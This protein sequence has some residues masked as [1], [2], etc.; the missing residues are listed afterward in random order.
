MGIP[1]TAAIPRASIYR[2][3]CHLKH[4]TGNP[5]TLIITTDLLFFLM[6]RYGDYHINSLKKIGRQKFGS[7]IPPHNCTYFLLSTIFQ[8]MKNQAEVTSFLIKEKRSSP[9]QRDLSPEEPFYRIIFSKMI[10][11][12]G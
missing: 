1:V 12:T 8:P 9:F 4:T 6:K 10:I 2:Y 11:S 7:H 5:L 3:P